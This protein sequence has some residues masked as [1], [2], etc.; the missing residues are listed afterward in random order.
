MPRHRHQNA[1]ATLARSTRT[2]RPALAALAIAASTAAAESPALAAALTWDATPGTGGSAGAQDGG[3]TWAAGGPNWRN[4]DTSTD[5]QIFTNGDAV[6]F[7]VGSG[8]GGTVPIDGTVTTNSVTF[9]AP[10][11]GNY[12]LVNGSNT[13][14]LNLS[15]GATINVASGLAPAINANVTGSNGF[16]KTG[17]GSLALGVVANAYTGSTTISQGTLIAN[18]TSSLGAAANTM[19]LGNASTGAN[20]VTFTIG[21]G[22]VDPVSLSSISTSN[23]GTSQTI[24]INGGSALSANEAGLLATLNL[25]GTVPLTIRATNTGGHST[26]QD[27]TGNITGTGIAAG[28]TALTLD[29][30]AQALRLTFGGSAGTTANTFTGDVVI[31]GPV[32]T[33]GTTFVAQVAGRQNMG[34]LNSNV[35]VQSGNWTIV[36]GGETVQALSGSGNIV[37]NNQNALNNVGLTIGNN[38]GGGTYSGVIS[39]GFGVAKVGN[40]T[41]TLTGANSYTGDTTIT[42]GRLAIGGAAERI[43]NASDLILSGGTFDTGGFS[44]TLAT[45]QITT[46]SNIDFGSGASVLTFAASNAVAWTGGTTLT[47]QNWSGSQTGG[48]TD[49]LIVGTTTSGLTATQLNQITFTGFPAGAQILS[50]GEVV[51]VPEPTAVGLI[52]VAVAGLAKRR[53]RDRVTDR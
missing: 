31:K 49:R 1:A 5:D 34:F 26:A 27:W 52:G 23:F 10:G 32:T 3:G 43:A 19:T 9:A 8:A 42:G 15:S 11:S 7:G 18:H 2:R 36:W 17:T 41:Q 44:E 22:V 38:N 33:Q 25:A 39:G 20:P 53:R 51:P 48:G 37:L 45:V 16:T 47:I 50:N 46:S 30:S 6:T 35:D 40:G 28:S 14:N 12:T 13:P 29:G 24:V 21:T 4:T